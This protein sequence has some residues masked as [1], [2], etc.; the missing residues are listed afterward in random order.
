[1]Q[2]SVAAGGGAWLVMN[3][4]L[5]AWN[6]YLPVLQRERYADLAG[7]LLPLVQTLLQVQQLGSN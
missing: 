4:A 3:A 1:M 6:N 7:L 5:S 2:L